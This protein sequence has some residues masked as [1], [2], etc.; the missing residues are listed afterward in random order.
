MKDA[1]RPTAVS[2][3]KNMAPG[4]AKEM[5]KTATGMTK[6]ASRKAVPAKK[7]APAKKA[8]ARKPAAR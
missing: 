6:A 2:T 1:A 3:T 8:A 7:R 4:L 5:V